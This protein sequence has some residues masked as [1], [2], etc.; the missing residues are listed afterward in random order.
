MHAPSLF[1]YSISHSE[2]LLMSL[3]LRSIRQHKK[4]QNNYFLRTLK[5]AREHDEPSPITKPKRKVKTSSQELT[6]SHGKLSKGHKDTPR[7]TE[8]PINN[9]QPQTA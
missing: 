6:Y 9:H 3:I 7:L 2:P 5:T 1:F 4:Y 8:R